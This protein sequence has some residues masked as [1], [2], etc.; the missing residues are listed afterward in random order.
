M[1]SIFKKD[2]R[3]GSPWCIDYTDE[4]GRRRRVVG[5]TDRTVTEQIARKLEAEVELRK[6]GIIS[7]RDDAYRR[8][9]ARSLAD[10]LDDFQA[11]LIGKGNVPR[12]VQQVHSNVGRVVSIGGMSRLSDL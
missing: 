9:E 11:D 12:Y 7:A 4:A 2:K 1:A 6:R 10:H 3:K 8:H 5:C